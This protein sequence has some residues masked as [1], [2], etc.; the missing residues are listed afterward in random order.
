MNDSQTT[1]IFAD[2]VGR[3]FASASYSG[4]FSDSNR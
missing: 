4:W 1:Q 3:K 2:Q